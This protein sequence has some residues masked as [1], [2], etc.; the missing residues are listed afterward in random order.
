MTHVLD[1]AKLGFEDVVAISSQAIDNVF[2]RVLSILPGAKTS[3]HKVSV[4]VP[5]ASRE[6]FSDLNNHA[7]RRAFDC[8]SPSRND[9]SADG[10][11]DTP[12]TRPQHPSPLRTH[13]CGGASRNPR[14]AAPDGG[15][16]KRRILGSMP[17]LIR[18][19]LAS[20][21]RS[22]DLKDFE[23]PVYVFATVIQLSSSISEFHSV[24]ICCSSVPRTCF[25]ANSQ[26][27]SASVCS[28]SLRTHA[29]Q[30][31]KRHSSRALP[32]FDPGCM[33]R[34]YP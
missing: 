20:S 9:D 13:G 14:E 22:I 25:A 31:S 5:A 21:S 1:P 3:G 34:W 27:L 19:F 8:L 6:F 11:A 15:R 12:C 28:A 26:R 30:H 18:K 4:V 23:R 2:P 33:Y 10:S 16:I 32:R 29:P 17:G 24:V 7:S